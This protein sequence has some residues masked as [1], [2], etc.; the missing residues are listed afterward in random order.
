M[1][2]CG[3]NMLTQEGFNVIWPF[4]GKRETEI[5]RMRGQTNS[6]EDEEGRELVMEWKRHWEQM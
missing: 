6:R 1:I 2:Q 4:G 3:A 5:D